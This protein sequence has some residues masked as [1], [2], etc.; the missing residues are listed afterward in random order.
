MVRGR[1]VSPLVDVQ[2]RTTSMSEQPLV[3][4]RDPK[5]WSNRSE[6]RR[7][8][9]DIVSCIDEAGIDRVRKRGDQRK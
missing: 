7:Q 9:A 8:L 6:R 5:V 4:I 3:T 2:N 1:S